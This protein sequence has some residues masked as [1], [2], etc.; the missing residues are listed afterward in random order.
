MI[1]K[2]E[3]W[4]NCF[5]WSREL[6]GR[7]FGYCTLLLECW[8]L[9]A[10]ATTG[11]MSEESK[12]RFF[13]YSRDVWFKKLGVGN[14]MVIRVGSQGSG[15]N[16]KNNFLTRRE[17]TRRR[18]KLGP[19]HFYHPSIRDNNG[20]TEDCTVDYFSLSKMWHMPNPL[21]CVDSLL[22]CWSL[23]LNGGFYNDFSELI[24]IPR[25]NIIFAH[26]AIIAKFI[27]VIQVFTIDKV[28]I[29]CEIKSFLL[30]PPSCHCT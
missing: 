29:K 21:T 26:P 25:R 10:Y 14:L 3:T 1:P 20:L 23:N 2:L 19:C 5:C 30:Q 9:Y 16:L 15:K 18:F 8:L 6:K 7:L 17:M 22:C 13:I 12:T 28:L 11:T 24:I 27:G 4:F